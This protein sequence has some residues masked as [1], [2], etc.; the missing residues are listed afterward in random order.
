[1]LLEKSEC[2]IYGCHC[3]K[4][5]G[6][7]TVAD[8]ACISTQ[9]KSQFFK[10]IFFYQLKAVK[11]CSVDYFYVSSSTAHNNNSNL[12]FYERRSITSVATRAAQRSFL[13]AYV[14]E[15]S[16]ESRMIAVN[17]P[18]ITTVSVGPKFP[19][20]PSICCS[21]CIYL[22]QKSTRTSYGTLYMCVR[23]FRVHGV[24]S[25]TGFIYRF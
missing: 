12:L 8:A 14:T 23:I 21:V 17:R 19:T 1:M 10:N 13:R 5:E 4:N 9:L 20:V 11:S 16:S 25:K 18:Y 15:R 7:L 24:I 22:P 2:I 3:T 6:Q